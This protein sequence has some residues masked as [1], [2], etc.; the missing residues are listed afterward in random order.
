MVDGCRP[1]L[2][3]TVGIDDAWNW[4]GGSDSCVGFGDGSGDRITGELQT[5]IAVDGR[6]GGPAKLYLSVYQTARARCDQTAFGWDKSFVCTM[7]ISG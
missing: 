5:D 7:T 4:A 1:G 3:S 2:E 6:S